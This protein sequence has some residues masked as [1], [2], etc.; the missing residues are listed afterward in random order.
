ML[1][2]YIRKKIGTGKQENISAKH[3][4]NFGHKIERNNFILVKHLNYEEKNGDG[5]RLEWKG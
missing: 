4:F 1:K 5:E 3:S 2:F